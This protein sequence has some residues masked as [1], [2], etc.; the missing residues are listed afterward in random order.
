MKLLNGVGIAHETT[1]TIVVKIVITTIVMHI[2]MSLRLDQY[3]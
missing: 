1:N 2:F 3:L